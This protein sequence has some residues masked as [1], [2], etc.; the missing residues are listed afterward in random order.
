V[1][2]TSDVKVFQQ[3]VYTEM[4]KKWMK[5][6]SKLP[7][8]ALMWQAEV[9]KPCPY[10]SGTLRKGMHVAVSSTL[11]LEASLELRTSVPYF[12]CVNYGARCPHG[13]TRVPKHF[14]E[15]GTREFAAKITPFLWGMV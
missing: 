5:V 15:Q 10:V 6:V 3:G 4:A 14:V 11:S 9:R 13:S 7:V 1:T 8:A 2:E 12:W